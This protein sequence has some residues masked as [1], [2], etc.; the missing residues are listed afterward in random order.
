[1]LPTLFRK[2]LFAAFIFLAVLALA[3]PLQAP[4]PPLCN[5]TCEP[6]QDT[7]NYDALTQARLLPRNTRGASTILPGDDPFSC[8]ILIAKGLG[9]GTGGIGATRCLPPSESYSYAIPILSLPGRNGLDVNLTLYY[10]S[11]IW[12]VDPASNTVTLNADRDFPGYGF[13]LGYGYIEGPASGG[14]LLT[15]PD[16]SK[17]ELRFK[18]GTKYET[19]DSSYIDYDSSTKV[20]RRKDGTQ[21]K[22]E[23]VGN[24]KI[25]R[26]KKITDTNGN[27]ITITYV[28]GKDQEINTITDTL[29]RVLTFTYDGGGKL[30]LRFR[31]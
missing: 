28:A 2:S 11:R 29:G 14:Y 15:E 17:R 12:T 4:T 6:D 25:F 23:Q 13:R 20:L 3:P 30:T 24:S 18:T 8:G 19:V 26:P 1:M 27:F 22:Y 21:W 7:P 10:N 31:R 16:G 9:G 5:G